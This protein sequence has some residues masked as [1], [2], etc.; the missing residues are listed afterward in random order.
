MA[1]LRPKENNRRGKLR[2]RSSTPGSRIRRI[3]IAVSLAVLGLLA[4]GVGIY[5]GVVT[6]FHH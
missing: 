1:A 6:S 3:L 5:L 2:R 4:A